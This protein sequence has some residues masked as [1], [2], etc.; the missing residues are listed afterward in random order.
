MEGVI[1]KRLFLNLTVS[2]AQEAADADK[3]DIV[4]NGTHGEETNAEGNLDDSIVMPSL[5]PS[6]FVSFH[7]VTFSFQPNTTFSRPSHHTD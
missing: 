3:A 7:C 4:E 2:Y 6:C 1:V 5:L